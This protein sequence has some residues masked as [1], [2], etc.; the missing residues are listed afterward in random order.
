[1]MTPPQKKKLDKV[2]AQLDHL[3]AQVERR[4]AAYDTAAAA[5]CQAESRYNDRIEELRQLASDVLG[6]DDAA[7]TAWLEVDPDEC[8][9]SATEDTTSI[10]DLDP[11][12]IR[13][14]LSAR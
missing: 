6:E 11:D 12:A 8:S 3:R 4:A 9:T 10:P 5:L 13:A 7:L 1:M 14:F 2:L